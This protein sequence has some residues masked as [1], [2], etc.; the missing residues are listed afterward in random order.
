MAPEHPSTPRSDDRNDAV[1]VARLDS[2]IPGLRVSTPAVVADIAL[3]GATLLAWRPRRADGT[4]PDDLLDGY[5]DP[6]EIAA[7]AGVRAGILAPFP[8]RIRDGLFTLAGRLHQMRPVVDG[9]S[10][11]FHG[12]ARVLPF[13]VAAIDSDADGVTLT[14]A[15]RI[16]PTAFAGYPHE[17]AVRVSYRFAGTATAVEIAATNLGDAPAPFAAGWHPYFRLPGRDAI[18]TLDLA[19]PSTTAVVTGDDLLPMTDTDGRV[20]T[21][22]EPSFR[23]GRSIGDAVL[24]VCFTDLVAGADGRIETRL[25]DPACGDALTVWQERGHMHVFTGDTLGRD[26]RRSIAL[27]PVEATTD[28][29][30]RPDQ[31]RRLLLAPGECRRFAFGFRYAAAR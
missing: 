28:A 24:D 26:R 7:Q 19:I 23:A 18:D 31:L 2:G 20:R 6:G 5:R 3:Q 8:N 13:A 15:T 25:S 27:E 14:L 22:P 17:V 29:F 10:L 16:A 1:G 11:V 30:N 4:T 21:R 9:E 12:F